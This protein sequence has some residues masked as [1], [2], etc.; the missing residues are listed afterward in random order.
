MELRTLRY[1]VTIAETG[2]VTAAAESLHVTQPGVS[3][4]LKSLETDLG[5][6][7][8]TREKG[9]LEL[10]GAGRSILPLARDVLRQ[11]EA[12]RVA[13]QHHAHG[14]LE[15][16]TIAAPATTLTDV[17]A[18]FVA[19]LLPHDPIPSVLESDGWTAE[20]SC[21]LGADLVLTL[22]SPDADRFD[23]RRLTSL[24][25]YACV[26][27]GHRL[28]GRSLLSVAELAGEELIGL[29][30]HSSARR[31][32]DD[33]VRAAGLPPLHLTETSNGTIAQALAAAG[34]GIALVTDEPRYDVLAL[35][36]TDPAGNRISFRLTC[37]WER[38]HPAAASLADLADRLE[39]WTAARFTS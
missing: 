14:R 6:A 25:V 29:P 33:A 8:F 26:P 24:P 23:S 3:R 22:D 31:V 37:A 35:P 17:V 34:R 20:K 28:A 12:L 16:L 1:F 9:R 19:S 5:V 18:P 10:T 11:A 32:V 27:A 39:A 13:A 21:S 38:A 36:L 30:A 4:Q 2:T 15:R 7:L